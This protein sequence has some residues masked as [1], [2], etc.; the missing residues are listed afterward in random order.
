[1]NRVLM[2]LALLLPITVSAAS[3]RVGS[4]KF[5]EGVILGD[6]VTQLLE[7]RGV[8]AE[9]RRELGGS[10]VLWSALL[11]GEIDVYPEY[12]GTLTEEILASEKLASADALALRLAAL[13]IGMTASLGFEDN[14][15]LGMRKGQ[16]RQLG[17]GKISDLARFP[18]LR[19]GF[20]NEFLER[21]DGWPSLRVHYSLP[22]EQV[23]GLD[24]DI[25]YRA[26]ADGTLDVIDLYSTDAEIRQFDLLTLAD[27]GNFFPRYEA[28]L[29]YRLDLPMRVPDALS[30]LTQLQ[31][32]ISVAR[33]IQ[34]NAA[35][36]IDQ[37]P[38]GGVAAEFLHQEMGLQSAA[39]TDT[40][41]N[42]F[43]RTTVDHLLLVLLS[44]SCAI[45]VAI[46]LGIWAAR[47]ADAARA[48]IGVASAIQT[49][50]ALALLVFL[51]P[52]LGIGFAP[53]VA[54]LF[55]YSLLPMVRNT[56]AGLHDIP[57]P[58]RESALALGLPPLARLRRIELPLA[59]RSILAGIKTAGVINVGTA[60]LGALI[61]AG[62][63][64]QP[65]LSG[66]RRDDFGLILEGAVPAALMALAVQGLFD[67]LERQA[68]PRGLRFRPVR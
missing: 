2:V 59:L 56:Y 47:R 12:T 14:Y 24:H 28:V 31:G 61:G 58:I 57:A 8:P 16:A 20:S 66:I 32:R 51:I 36:R 39:I 63:Y 55:L 35:V 45:V 27:D 64:G 21:S 6:I 68:I 17:I 62:G 52:L 9:H 48:I 13:G 15:V 23:R 1:M 38:E 40:G 5:T 33:M 37:K 10:S 26:L 65:I 30:I 11:A 22:Q 49:I 54:A 60:T 53:A 42:R 44:L 46:P 43:R 7:A 34:M 67:L 29:L 25:S 3:V 18:V 19:V 4:K 41:L 50:P